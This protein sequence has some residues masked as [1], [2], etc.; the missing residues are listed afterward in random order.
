MRYINIKQ[1]PSKISE[2]AFG[3]WRMGNFT[4]A[5]AAQAV[6]S[7]LECG[8]NFFDNATCYVGGKSEEHFGTAMKE[9]GL[10]RN[11]IFIQ[12][13]VGIDAENGKFDWS[14]EYILEAVEG[15]LKRMGTDY[16]DVLLLHRPD[17]IFDPDEVA[18]AFDKL[19]VSGKVKYFGVSNL[20]PMQIELLKK[21]VDQKLVFNQLHFSLTEAQL[22]DHILYMDQVGQG[23]GEAGALANCL[24]G[25]VLDYCRLNG[26]TIQTWSPLQFG[27]NATGGQGTF[28]GRRDM[29]PEL[30]KKL[31][32]L[33]E[34]YNVPTAAIAIAWILRHPAHM[35]PILGTMNGKHL[36]EAAM[37][38][39][40]ELTRQEWYDLYLSCR[41]R[42][43]P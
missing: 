12:S 8:I 9:L 24:N 36:A 29:F 10:N 31:D 15:S 33:S 41:N 4:E 13:K 34:K 3:A 26:I 17:L 38:S 6:N 18:A 23:E 37:G 32:E 2:I 1:G 42:F 25:D 27:F 20:K 16:L 30:N 14:E 11:D 40:V 5:E 43:L 39:G 28:L 19:Y 22:I 35:Q 21:S 7:A